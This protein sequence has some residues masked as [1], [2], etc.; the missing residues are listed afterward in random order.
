MISK[1]HLA[2]YLIV[3]ASALSM[4]FYSKVNMNIPMSIHKTRHKWDNIF[5]SI[6]LPE[7]IL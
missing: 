5:N 2:E 7:Q 6:N 4:I 1:L 3:T